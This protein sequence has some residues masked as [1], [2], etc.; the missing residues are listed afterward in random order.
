M[1]TSAV[2]RIWHIQDSQGQILALA[3][4]LK[5]LKLYKVFPFRVDEDRAVDAAERGGEFEE[6]WLEREEG[7]REALVHPHGQRPLRNAECDRTLVR[8]IRL[9]G[10][11]IGLRGDI[12]GS[13]NS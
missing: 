7:L 11:V 8:A 4:R 2:E 13:R 1:L 3:L 6:P 5:S 10:D 9:K 12:I